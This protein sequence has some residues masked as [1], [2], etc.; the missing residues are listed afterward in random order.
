MSRH[1]RLCCV[2]ASGMTLIG[3]VAALLQSAGTALADE[4]E[5]FAVFELG[6]AGEWGLNNGSGS[7]FG[8]VAAVELTPIKNWLVIEP[9]VTTLFSRRQTELD[10]DFI[11]KKPFDLSPTVEF[12]PGIG[13]VWMHT[14]G[15]GRITDSVGAEGVFDFVF[16]PTSDRKFGWFLEP[17]YSYFFSSGHEQSLGVSGGLLIPI[18]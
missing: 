1:C 11:F 5:P 17:S 13:P 4:K 3:L 10:T 8:P 9:G 12:E 15:S 18:K 2:S 7:S 14:V 6:A 16:W